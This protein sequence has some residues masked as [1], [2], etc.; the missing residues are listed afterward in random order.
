[1]IAYVRSV[2]AQPGPMRATHIRLLGRVGIVSGKF[3]PV[4]TK[5]ATAPQH[6]AGIPVSDLGR[7]GEYLVMTRCT[8][9]HGTRLQG[10]GIVK[11]PPLVV[12]AAYS[13]TQLHDL[14]HL[15]VLIGN[16]PPGLMSE[17]SKARF[18]AFDDDELKAI[19]AYL[20]EAVLGRA[21][22]PPRP[23][24]PPVAGARTPAPGGA[25]P[26][27]AAPLLH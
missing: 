23:A 8:E 16:R 26:D 18:S 14:L 7:R 12:A 19:Y 11:A 3:V 25:F 10:S 9:C 22:A 27:P 17:T 24:A 4:V 5:T 21:S 2:P 6:P 1:L 20:Q 13:E 15:G